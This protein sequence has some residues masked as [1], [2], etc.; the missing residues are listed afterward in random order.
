[1]YRIAARPYSRVVR[2]RHGFVLVGER[3]QGEDRAED[4]LRQDLRA[5]GRIGEQ[6]GSV[7]QA[8]ELVVGS[9]AEDR[10]GTVGLGALDESVDALEVF[11]G[12]LRADVG[13]RFSRV[14]LHDRRRRPW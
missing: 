1:M 6:R 5:G 8:P 2:Q 9:T 3:L 11:A 13:G 12:D 14:P 7:V 4:L 10:T